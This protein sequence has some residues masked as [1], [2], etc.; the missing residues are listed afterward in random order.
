MIRLTKY[1][2]TILAVVPLASIRCRVLSRGRPAVIR[3]KTHL[4]WNYQDKRL[5]SQQQIQETQDKNFSFLA[6]YRPSE[7]KFLRIADDDM[8]E[9][10]TSPEHCFAIGRNIVPYELTGNLDG[11]RFA[12][13]YAID[14][15]TGERKLAAKKSR[16]TMPLSPT[17]THLDYYDDGQVNV[18]K[19]PTAFFGW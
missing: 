18:V 15:Q 1:Q 13:V 7:K 5:Q 6:V 19:P 12:D 10:T 16:W 4:I 9:V 3:S 11:R 17:G 14:L 8:R 2:L